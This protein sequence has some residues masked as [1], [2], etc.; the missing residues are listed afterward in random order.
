MCSKQVDNWH[1]NCYSENKLLVHI[2][3]HCFNDGRSLVSLSPVFPGSAL[4]DCAHQWPIVLPV[5]VLDG[6]LIVFVHLKIKQILLLGL[7]LSTC[8][9]RAWQFNKE[10]LKESITKTCG[11]SP[12]ENYTDRAKSAK[13]VPMFVDR[14]C[15]VVSVTVPYGF[16]DRSRYIFFSNSSTIAPKR[17]SG[18][19]SRPTTSKKSGVYSL[20]NF[21]Q[22]DS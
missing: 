19:R 15:Y 22:I 18:F 11:Q 7:C 16:L 21:L 6:D 9:S 8:E 13:L 3:V 4:R 17:L 10:H 14:R 20:I 5:S 12:R 2:G 1:K